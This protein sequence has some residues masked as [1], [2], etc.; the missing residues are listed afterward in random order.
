MIRAKI[1][2]DQDSF[3]FSKLNKTRNAE[4][5]TSTT[6][7]FDYDIIELNIKINEGIFSSFLPIL[8]C[9]P[10]REQR[11]RPIQREGTE[12]QRSGGQLSGGQ[13]WISR[14]GA[15]FREK[16]AHGRHLRPQ[17]RPAE[18]SRSP[19]WGAT[20]TTRLRLLLL[21][22]GWILIVVHPSID[23]TSFR[24]PV[25]NTLSFPRF[26]LPPVPKASV[27]AYYHHRK[28]R[29]RTFY[30]VNIEYVFSINCNGRGKYFDTRFPPSSFR[31]LSIFLP[32]ISLILSRKMSFA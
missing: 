9:F 8:F 29:S 26:L 16:R 7:S 30:I 2:H 1:F 12:R 20:G 28:L 17:S 31:P 15:H 18:S 3:S 19:R 23:R 11:V 32:R 5:N 21:G 25:I 10:R 27:I 24:Y 13:G 4:N 22:R 6:S 14:R